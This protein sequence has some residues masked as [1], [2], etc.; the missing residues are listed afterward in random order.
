MVRHVESLCSKKMVFRQKFKSEGIRPPQG[1]LNISRSVG[2]SGS[3]WKIYVKPVDIPLSLP[4]THLPPTRSL[5][6]FVL[7]ET[8]VNL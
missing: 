1:G 7:S 2:Y 3:E 8:E 5:G 6:I 4:L